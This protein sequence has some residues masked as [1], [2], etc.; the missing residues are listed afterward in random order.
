MKKTL[1]ALFAFFLLA[2]AVGVATCS[3][4]PYPQE[5]KSQRSEEKYRARLE[6]EVRHQLVMLPWYSVFDN[7]AFQVEGDKVTLLGQVTRPTLKSD[8]EAAVK[9]IEG[10]ASVVNNIE[11]L[12]V[13]PMDDQLRRAVFRAIYSD[14]GLQRYAIQAVPSIHIIVK[15]GSVTLEGVVDNQTDKN[16]ANLRASQVPN[17]FSVKNN[18]SVA[19]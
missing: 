9:S 6:K 1:P 7:L 11:V 18:L 10:V 3:A 16:I 14:P 2:A 8:A 12:P 5:T 19:K 15:N 4:V 17:V 13:S